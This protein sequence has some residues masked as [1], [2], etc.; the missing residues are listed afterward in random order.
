MKREIKRINNIYG[1]VEFA[2]S[3]QYLTFSIKPAQVEY[4]IIKLLE[5]VKELEPKLILEIGTAGGGTLFLFSRI[6]DPEAT[7]L[8]IDLPGGA[9][10]GG[11]PE[12][13]MSLFQGFAKN[14]QKIKLLRADS[15]DLNT[16][17][18]VKEILGD[19]LLD[20]LFIDGD[21][22]YEGV[23][24]D[25]EMYSPLVRKGGIIAFHDI[26]S[27]PPENV[28]GVPEFW[29]EIKSGYRHLEVVKDWNQGGY[30]IGVLY[31]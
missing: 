9:F 6:A 20:F 30:G 1:A 2:F 10:G 16:L 14:G 28:G 18:R 26:V 15:H 25:F 21:H 11:Y 17:R 24:R 7:I 4:E 5:I 22:T 29:N 8:S 19:A 12:W 23:K 13:K 31:V 27:G 3:F